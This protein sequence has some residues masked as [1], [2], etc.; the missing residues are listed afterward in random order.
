MKIRVTTK[1]IVEFCKFCLKNRLYKPGVLLDGM[2]ECYLSENI[3]AIAIA[4][5]GDIP[6]GAGIVTS[7]TYN[8]QIW[9]KPKHRRKG[10]GTALY[11]KLIQYTSNNMTYLENHTN[12][13]FWRKVNEIT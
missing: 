7:S 3:D 11:K 2:R 12:S 8:L 1:N 6:I 13:K 10:I 4:F 5:D 9:V